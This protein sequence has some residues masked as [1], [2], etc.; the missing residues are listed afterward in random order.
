MFCFTLQKIEEVKDKPLKELDLLRASIEEAVCRRIETPKDFRFL[1]EQIYGQTREV[2]SPTTLKRL[3][4]YLSEEVIPHRSTLSILAHFA[5]Y[6]S[7]DDFCEQLSRMAGELNE[8]PLM[9]EAV[10]GSE[11][12]R[13][14]RLDVR[15]LPDSHLSLVCRGNGRFEVMESHHSLLARG[16]SMRLGLV[17][18]GKPLYA[19]HIHSVNVAHPSMII[20][21]RTGVEVYVRRE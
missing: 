13:G 6:A 16:D 7:W 11:M 17:F 9:V 1:T 14:E 12:G 4:G 20:A 15:W 18:R 21:P 3:W 5:G 19:T 8:Q 10:V 2:I